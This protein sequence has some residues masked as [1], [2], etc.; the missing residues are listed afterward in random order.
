MFYKV[1]LERTD[2]GY[3]VSCP[4]LPGCWSQG[5]SE[6]EA[7]GNIKSAIEEYLEVL[8]DQLKGADV[9]EVEVS[10]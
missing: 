7:L 5:E 4:V 6:L 3:S 2:E 9:R 1:V 10:I 8:N